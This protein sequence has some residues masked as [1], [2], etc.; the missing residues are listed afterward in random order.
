MQR[1]ITTDYTNT[2]QIYDG[3]NLYFIYK[4]TEVNKKIKLFERRSVVPTKAILVIKNNA[5]LTSQWNVNFLRFFEISW[6]S[7]SRCDGRG[8]AQKKNIVKANSN[9]KFQ[10]Q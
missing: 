9:E 2:Y 4:L 5:L 3:S 8:C 6:L 1:Y 10:R 7:E